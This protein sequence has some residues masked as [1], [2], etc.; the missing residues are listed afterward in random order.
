MRERKC[1][2][3]KLGSSSKKIWCNFFFLLNLAR[4]TQGLYLLSC[5]NVVFHFWQRVGWKATLIFSIFLSNKDKWIMSIFLTQ[6]ILQIQF[7]Y[8]LK[9]V[10]SWS[11]FFT[12]V[13]VW[14]MLQNVCVLEIIATTEIDIHRV[15][16]YRYLDCCNDLKL[17]LL[18][19]DKDF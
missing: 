16:K 6:T 13:H 3:E 12:H 8:T 18:F 15:V 11:H 17:L 4:T 5:E 9:C 2:S 1:K 7:F 19:N 14:Q 10:K